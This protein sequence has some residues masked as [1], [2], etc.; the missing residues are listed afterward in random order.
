MLLIQ[1]EMFKALCFLIFPIVSLA[2]G[3]IPTASP[4][5]QASGFFLAFGLE[6]SG[7]LLHP[8]P[9]SCRISN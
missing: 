1:S 7:T 8:Y 9:I 6:S 5:C 4:F 3:G 2:T